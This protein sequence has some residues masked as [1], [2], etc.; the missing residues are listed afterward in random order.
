MNGDR[1]CS[2]PQKRNLRSVKLGGAYRIGLLYTATEFYLRQREDVPSEEVDA[3]RNLGRTFPRT[4]GPK[5]TTVKF[6][7]LRSSRESRPDDGVANPNAREPRH[8]S[9]ARPNSLDH[10]CSRACHPHR[11]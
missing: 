2:R 3:V 4:S 7:A 1:I 11:C 10:G 6:I 8:N 5:L 9:A